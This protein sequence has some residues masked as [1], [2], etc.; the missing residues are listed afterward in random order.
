MHGATTELIHSEEEPTTHYGTNGGMAL[1]GANGKILVAVL[2]V[3]LQ[4]SAG[5]KIELTR[6]LEALTKRCGT[7]GGMVLHG[8]IGKVSA[9]D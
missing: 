1:T 7:N 6:L 3:L 2:Q 4:R 8:V 5:V 9:E